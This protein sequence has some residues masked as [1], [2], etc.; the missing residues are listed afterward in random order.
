MTNINL[1]NSDGMDLSFFKNFKKDSANL[2]FNNENYN[3]ANLLY[4]R[5]L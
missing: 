3:K 2:T 4:K 5:F 1:N